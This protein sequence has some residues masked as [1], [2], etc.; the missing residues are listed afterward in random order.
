MTN[1]AITVD[2]A[3]DVVTFLKAQHQQI[4]ALFAEVNAS[5]GVDREEAFTQLRR[6]LAVHETAEEE[7]VHP[8]AKHELA[9]GETVVGARLQEEHEAK[10]ALA[11]LEKLN[12]DSTEFQSKFAQFEKDVVAHA[13]AEEHEEF[14]EL[15][16]ELDDAQLER[17]RNAVKLAEK[18]APTHPHPGV[19]SQAENMMA[20]PFAMMLDRAKDLIT[21]KR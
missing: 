19:E 18:M 8:R 9:N 20:G 11:E 6:L 7:V 17:M 2:N 4:K 1:P 12:I 3:R 5:S 16:H 14:A 10:E 15:A 21:G 13:E